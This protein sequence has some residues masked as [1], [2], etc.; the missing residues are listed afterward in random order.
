MVPHSALH[1]E[2]ERRKELQEEVKREREVRVRVEERTNALLQRL[3]TA[4]QPAGGE[5]TPVPPDPATDTVGALRM[6]AAEVRELQQFRHNIETQARHHEAVQGVVHHAAAQ[7]AEFIKATPDYPAAG[8]FL[9]AA[10][11]A[12]LAAVGLPP[13]NRAQLIGAETLQLA[14]LAI[15]QNR[16]PAE[17]V[18]SLARSRGYAP[19]IP[20][21]VAPAAGT[22]AGAAAETLRR[23]A[24]G[25][26]AG[27]SLGSLAG[28]APA[29][30]ITAQA[31]ATMSDAE[32]DRALAGLSPEQ[33]RTLFGA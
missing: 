26:E 20:A 9:R 5:A 21:A 22:R 32:F 17:L 13:E 29:G 30:R 27:A 1:E 4:L 12:E 19:P 15:Q 8:E 14:A 7:E 25:Q 33:A 31:L 16:N 18:Y 24:A 3:A 10:R 11:E 23:V 6:T 2:R 28:S